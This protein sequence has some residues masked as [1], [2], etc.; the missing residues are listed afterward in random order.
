MSDFMMHGFLFELN[1]TERQSLH[2]II[3]RNEGDGS[4]REEQQH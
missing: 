4:D 3:H 1:S 2:L